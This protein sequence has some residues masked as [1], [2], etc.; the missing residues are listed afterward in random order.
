MSSYTP[1]QG[2][3]DMIASHNRERREKGLTH[4]N[5]LPK[6]F[7]LPGNMPRFIGHLLGTQILPKLG[8][9]V[10]P[11][12]KE[13]KKFLIQTMRGEEQRRKNEILREQERIRGRQMRDEYER[14]VAI[15]NEEKSI[16]G[17]DLFD[18]INNNE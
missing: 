7:K 5:M 11:L 14:L 15:A 1:E 18:K 8:E 17:K 3:R 6:D 10:K 2:Y 9:E 16:I 4:V 13:S 12:T